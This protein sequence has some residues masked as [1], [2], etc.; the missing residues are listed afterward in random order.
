MAKL[1]KLWSRIWLRGVQFS[2]KYSRLEKL[3]M[4]EDPWGLASEREHVRF[5]RTNAL[6]EQVAPGCNSVLEIGCGEGA[7][8]AWLA[9]ICDNVT[10]LDV[11]QRA[12]ARARVRVPQARFLAGRAEDLDTLLP[13]E[14]FGCVLACE[15]LYYAADPAAV[16]AAMQGKSDHVLVTV[17]RPEIARLAPIMAG[18]GWQS[19]PPIETDE[20]CWDCFVWHRPAADQ[21]IA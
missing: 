20:A 6:L 10:G 17:Y 18:A 2:G 15:V 16:I 3:Y 4:V 14:S 7:Q 8:T 21:A 13:G 19:L 1:A 5:A 12:V 9:K 11:S